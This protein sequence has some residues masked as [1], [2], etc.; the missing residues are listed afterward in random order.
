MD[1]TEYFMEILE[2]ELERIESVKDSFLQVL[3]F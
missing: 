3:S 1:K 2:M